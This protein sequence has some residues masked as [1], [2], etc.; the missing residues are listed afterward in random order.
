MNKKTLVHAVILIWAILVSQ[1]I[2]AATVTW[3]STN[4]VWHCASCWVWSPSG[5]GLPTLTDNVIVGPVSS[6]DTF[7]NFDSSTG[8]QSVSSLLVNSD[9]ANTI[10]FLQS[11]GDL[12]LN[13]D[14]IV[15]ST[16]TGT[17][18]QSGGTNQVTG[19]PLILGAN[20]G[21]NGAYNL[22]SGW[23]G[24]YNEKVGL[25]GTGTFTQSGGTNAT[26]KLY[27][28]ANSGSSGTYN[29]S[30]S[31]YLSANDEY[32]GYDG[33]GTFT[34]SGGT[35]KVGALHLG[36]SDGTYNLSDSGSIS[37]YYE[38]VGYHGTG[39]FTQSSGTNTMGTNLI[40]GASSGSDGTYNLTG[41][42]L[43]VNSNL[44]YPGN[45]IVGSTGTGTFNQSGGNH[46]VNG[47]LILA[48]NTGGD[49][50]YNLTGGTLTVN[51]GIT[52][53]ANGTFN[54]GAGTT[55]TVGGTGFANHGLLE[56]SG[57]ISG[58]VTSDGTVGPGN[59]PGI[60]SITG[61]Y[62]QSGLGTYAVE[63]GGSSAGQYD[64]LN[65]SGSAFLDG[66]LDVS[67]FDLGGG[68]FT[69]HLGDYFDILTADGL[70]GTFSS[71][72]FAAL[73]DPSLSWNIDYINDGV[74]GIA[75]MVRLSI[76]SNAV[77]PPVPE[78]EAYAML[79]AGLGLMAFVMRR[80]KQPTA[81][82]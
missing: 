44:N 53:N 20:S 47:S 13:G 66:I 9:T 74:G 40:L 45:E 11:G 19:A 52:N 32:V 76:A 29:L 77:S 39:T 79:L 31:G 41:G 16:G 18:N 4:D 73:T 63:I 71:L 69:P 62:T 56:G 24:A 75:D 12:R 80:R 7:L 14:E 64:V 28:G 15:G 42:T 2:Q 50:T 33:T 46:Q 70:L 37:A 8:T 49:G 54:L 25:S 26:D 65:V 51:N 78:P 6:T 21:S 3:D 5:S 1:S 22:E 58:N 10:S 43:T 34:Q 35:N 57:T 48:D 82:T 68:L 59:S 23:L 72:S 55:A 81:G 36:G 30:D 38:Y 27:L 67:L 17:F 61:S 60:L